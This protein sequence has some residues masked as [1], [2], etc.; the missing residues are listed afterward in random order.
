MHRV[1]IG[2][3]GGIDAAILP[4]GIVGSANRWVLWIG[5]FPSDVVSAQIAVGG[6][7]GNISR[8][9][10]HRPDDDANNEYHYQRNNSPSPALPERAVHL[11]SLFL[12]LRLPSRIFRRSCFRR[13]RFA[14]LSFLAVRC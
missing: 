8:L 14:L 11:A 6:D 13:F 5:H 7:P 2:N 3:R 10:A 12:L 9:R 1:F 4:D